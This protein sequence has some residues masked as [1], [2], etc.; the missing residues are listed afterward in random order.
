MVTRI[1]PGLRIAREVPSFACTQ[2]GYAFITFA[3]YSDNGVVLCADC[4]D[5]PQP[6]REMRSAELLQ[7]AFSESRSTIC[8][9]H[10]RMNTSQVS[11]AFAESSFHLGGCHLIGRI[12]RSRF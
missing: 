1:T 7:L 3:N 8:R 5:R 10:D 2:V 12:R 4:D 6:L 11:R 9:F